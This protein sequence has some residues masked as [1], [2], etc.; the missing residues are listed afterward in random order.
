MICDILFYSDLILDGN[1]FLN[2]VQNINTNINSKIKNIEEYNILEYDEN[3]NIHSSVLLINNYNDGILS[4]NVVLL[5]TFLEGNL[6]I[7]NVSW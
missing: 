1:S 7:N 3:L 2:I 5:K 6:L 4:S